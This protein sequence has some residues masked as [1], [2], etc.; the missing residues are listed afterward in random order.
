M[1][2]LSHYTIRQEDFDSLI[3]KAVNAGIEAYKK[4][5]GKAKTKA[6]N[7]NLHNTR[8]LL[9][10]YRA[11]K[12]DIA[13]SDYDTMDAQHELRF[14]CVEDLMQPS[15]KSADSRMEKI[16]AD[17]IT[18]LKEGAWRIRQIERAL[19]LLEE[20]CKRQG[21]PEAMRKYRILIDSYISDDIASQEEIAER[22][23]ISERMVRYDVQ[24]ALK[25]ITP[26]LFT[27]D[28]IIEAP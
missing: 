11:V 24:E 23:H 8:K 28:A 4:A 5:E 14:K 6:V 19:D 7:R 1:G 2:K 27:I 3:E 22:E 13:H 16:M 12:N 21:T 26:Y 9:E 17:E 20:D 15:M 10:S 18:R 25:M